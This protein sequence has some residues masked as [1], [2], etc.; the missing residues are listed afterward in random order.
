MKKY[1]VLLLIVCL[2]IV[3]A[4][5]EKTNPNIEFKNDYESING[6]ENASGKIHRTV[7]IP[8]DNPFEEV[9]ASEIVKK[10]ENKETF[11]VYFGSRLCPWCRSVIESAS[12]LANIRG[13]SKIYYVDIWDDE[14]KEILRDKYTL[15]DDNK[16]VLEK[17]GTDEYKKLLEY[18]S[19]F[20]R[21]YTLTDTN[22]KDVMVGEK[23]IYAP[24]FMFI[25]NGTLK[26]LVTGKSDKLTDSRGELTEEILK[27]QERI[28]DDFFTEVCDEEC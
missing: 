5:G 4:C 28:F 26:K 2:F 20:L 8:D 14:G 15:D 16:P 27:D 9:E 21:D 1:F 18:F 22:N 10:I 25:E 6:K 23:R 11:Y 7:T 12:K 13:I 19:K 3:T 24:N 17:D